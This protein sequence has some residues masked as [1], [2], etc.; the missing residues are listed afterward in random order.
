MQNQFLRIIEE[1]TNSM[2]RQ[3][4]ESKEPLL[5]LL[6]ALFDKFRSIAQAHDNAIHYMEVISR[7]HAMKNLQLYEISDVWREAQIAVILFFFSFIKNF[8]KKIHL[9][10][11]NVD[12]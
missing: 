12:F 7:K 10:S 3:I 5:D 2:K 8:K 6:R 4:T 9:K 1:T 11:M